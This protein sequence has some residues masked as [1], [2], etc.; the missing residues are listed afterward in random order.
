MKHYD[1]GTIKKVG[2]KSVWPHEA[3]DFTK[4]LAEES[5]LALL[6]EA[7]GMDLELREVESAVGSFRA[8]IYA[9]DTAT[10]ARVIIENQLED[11]NHDHLGKIITYAAGKDAQ[12]V[13]WIVRHARD[14]HRQAIEWLNAHTDDEAAFFLVEIEVWS[15][16]DSL[17]APR[18]NVVE[19]PNEWARAIKASE[20]L[21]ETDKIKLA[22]WTRYREVAEATPEFMKE[23]SPRKPA[24]NHWSTLSCESSAYHMALLI[25]TQ[26]GRTGVEFYVPDDKEI[27]HRAIANVVIFEQRLGLKAKVFDATKASGIRLYKTG[28]AVSTQQD[29]WD[30]FIKEQLGWALEMKKVIRELE[31]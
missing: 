24:K 13:I 22:Y 27:G 11:T 19:Q 17:P 10:N 25:D 6:S 29:K 28:R 15:I 18:F 8:D 3:L 4:W 1:L 16:G 20:G 14:E 2:L 23:F 7:V 5:S 21:S 30:D 12:A 9:A 26:G 31:L